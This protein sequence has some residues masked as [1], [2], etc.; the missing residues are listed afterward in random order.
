[1]HFVQCEN[2]LEM[3]HRLRLTEKK[4]C[5]NHTSIH[6]NSAVYT[7]RSLPDSKLEDLLLLEE[8]LIRKSK[9]RLTS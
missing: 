9:F 8:I 7:T 6:P 1:M 3:L 2:V 5:E 4:H